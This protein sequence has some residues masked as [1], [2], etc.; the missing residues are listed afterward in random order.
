M[1]VR[2]WPGMQAP[3]IVG[4]VATLWFYGNKAWTERSTDAAS[5]A[6]HIMVVAFVLSVPLRAFG[7]SLGLAA[8]LLSVLGFFVWL[9]AITR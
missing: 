4:A 9:A 6:R 1:T 5:V 8:L 7:S 2:Q 3:A